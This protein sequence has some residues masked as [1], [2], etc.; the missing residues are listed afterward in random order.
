M[1]ATPQHRHHPHTHELSFLPKIPS[2]L[3]PRRSSSSSNAQT[4]GPPPQR[5]PQPIFTM[6]ANPQPQQSQVPYSQRAIKRAPAVSQDALKERRRG[7]FLRKVR[8]GREESRWGRRGE[9]V[10]IL[11]A[12]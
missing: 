6:S 2:P 3:S 10:S 8:E 7:M 12:F 11:L 5:P 4:H 1:L 9:D